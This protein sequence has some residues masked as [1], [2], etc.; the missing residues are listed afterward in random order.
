MSS[1]RFIIII[2]TRGSNVYERQSRLSTIM[3]LLLDEVEFA[4]SVA[5][6]RGDIPCA[7]WSFM[8]ILSY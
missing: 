8:D 1:L 6:P 4:R 5:Y 3:R 7:P 2:A